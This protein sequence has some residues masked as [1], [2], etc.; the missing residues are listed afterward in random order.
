M[1]AHLGGDGQR[2]GGEGGSEFRGG[3]D[4]QG[5]CCGGE[6]N[7]IAAVGSLGRTGDR[8]TRQRRRGG[9]GGAA[10]GGEGGSA[11][12]RRTGGRVGGGAEQISGRGG[13]RRH[14]GARVG[15]NGYKCPRARRQEGGCARRGEGVGGGKGG[16]DGG[17]EGARGGGGDGGGGGGQGSRGRA[18]ELDGLRAAIQNFK[19]VVVSGTEGQICILV[20]VNCS[21]G[22]GAFGGNVGAGAGIRTGGIVQAAHHIEAADIVLAGGLPIDLG[23]LSDDGSS[24]LGDIHGGIGQADYQGR[25]AEIVGKVG[26]TAGIQGKFDLVRIHQAGGSLSTDPA[27]AAALGR[28][29]GVIP[30]SGDIGGRVIPHEGEKGRVGLGAISGA[31]HLVEAGGVEIV[32]ERDG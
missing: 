32:L 21:D 24:E 31:L 7:R 12:V 9:A 15:A 6:L 20:V 2:G 3:G 17:G 14:E 22:G 16:S 11:Q 28:R 13:E 10:S 5:G 26:A 18:D 25:E 19:F 29:A 1:G 23:G 8:I 30:S 27:C 4:G